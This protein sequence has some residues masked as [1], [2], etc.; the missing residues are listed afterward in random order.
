MAAFSRPRVRKQ[1]PHCVP[2]RPTPTRRLRLEAL[3]DRWVPAISYQITDVNLAVVLSGNTGAV[4]SIALTNSGTNTLEINGVDT[5]ILSADVLLVN[6]VGDSAGAANDAIDLS[7]VA[8]SAFAGLVLVTVDGGAGGNALKVNDQAHDFFF[9]ATDGGAGSVITSLS[10]FIDFTAIGSFTGG[11]GN[12][13]FVFAD[14]VGAT[15][16][17]DGGGGVNTLDYS[18][19]TT[20]VSVNLPTGAATNVF[21]GLAGGVTGVEN[22]T[23]GFGNDTLLGDASSNV[24]TGNDGNDILATGPGGTDALLGGSGNDTFRVAVAAGMAVTIQ[25]GN[26]NDTIDFSSSLLT[27]VTVDLD[28]FTPQTI[29]AGMSLQFTGPDVVENFIGTGVSDTVTVRP[30]GVPRSIDGNTPVLPTLPGD[31]VLLD[32]TSPPLPVAPTGQTF[33]Y[34]G[35]GD[36]FYT[37]NEYAQVTFTSIETF[38][39]TSP[40]PNLVINANAINRD[41]RVVRNGAN[42]EIRDITNPA[43]FPGVPYFVYAYTSFDTLTINGRTSDSNRV[44]LDFI[45]G[46]VANTPIQPLGFT[47]NGDAI[48]SGPLA[49]VDRLDIASGTATAAFGT[50]SVAYTGTESGTSSFTDTSLNALGEIAF[51]GVDEYDLSGGNLAPAYDFS[52][53]IQNLSFN[54][55]SLTGPLAATFQDSG[56]VADGVSRV[57]TSAPGPIQFVPTVFTNPTTQLSVS[58]GTGLGNADL[59]QLGDMDNNFAPTDLVFTG[60]DTTD[61]YRLTSTGFLNTPAPTLTLATTTFDMNG[62]SDTVAWVEDLADGT[63]VLNLGSAATLTTGDAT[64][65]T[66]N[67]VISG[68]GNFIKQGIGSWTLGGTLTNTYTGSATVNEGSLLLNKGN[69]SVAVGGALNIGDDLG[70]NDVDLVQLIGGNGQIISTSLVRVNTTGLLSLNNF[71]NTIGG[72]TMESGTTVAGTVTM[73]LGTLTLGTGANVTLSPD[74]APGAVVPADINGI[75]NL[76]T[77]SHTF[78]IADGTTVV[79]GTGAATDVDLLVNA[80]VVGA[81]D[82]IKTGTGLV[83]LTSTSNTY[84]GTTTINQGVFNL[85]GSLT[86]AGGGVILNGPS[87][88]FSGSDLGRLVGDGRGITVTG[89]ASSNATISGFVRIFNSTVGATGITVQSGAKVR[90]IDNV[91]LVAT[92]GISGHAV[93]ILV[94]GATDAT[95]VFLRGNRI[96]SN[97]AS[98]SVG[99]RIQGGAWV[100]AGQKNN[101]FDFTGLR[102]NLASSPL[103]AGSNGG[104]FFGQA[105][106]T[107]QNA[108]STLYGAIRNQNNNSPNSLAGPQGAPNDAY[109][110]SNFFNGAASAPATYGTIEGLVYHD[111]DSSPLGFV[112]YITP[113]SSA[114]ALVGSPL[115]YSVTPTAAANNN[116]DQR[117]MIRRIRLSFTDFVFVDIGTALNLQRTGGFAATGGNYIGGITVQRNSPVVFNPLA[118]DGRYFNYDFNFTGNGVEVSG[119]LVDG[120]YTLAINGAGIQSYVPFTPAP[121]YGSFPALQLTNPPASPLAFH[122]LFGDFNN[123]ATVNNTP[124]VPNG[125]TDQ[126]QFNSTY[127]SIRGQAKYLEYFDFDNDGDVDISDQTQF[128]RRMNRY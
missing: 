117:S 99:L 101:G 95:R 72:L 26:G 75:L 49:G 96:N 59:V 86:G 108:T 64:N 114:P 82:V 11:A 46:S 21:G 56:G 91:G 12:D 69:G 40:I 37:S 30:L 77:G 36:S 112:N 65:H 60:D 104:N 6:L 118:T 93:N 76:V 20:D 51:T 105:G 48:N 17:I 44:I 3:E 89:G 14:G 29:A 92:D 22:A 61:I 124:L 125:P 33:T 67:G 2:S 4:D 73:G 19:Y 116:W 62:F 41:F 71:N 85:P 66:Y 88:V 94:N 78:N 57:V 18:S 102:V 31:T 13:A 25:D 111:Y 35:P 10:Y 70:G 23:G 110:Q 9:N 107:Y 103:G 115:L 39:S 50:I 106:A 80:T 58:A 38:S 68:T 42:V 43:Y 32:N 90:I 74:G 109:A 16:T 97:A 126:T 7:G 8:P 47:F 127:R 128:N 24:L 28:S 122:R 98:T 119:S 81:G 123:T 87:A 120:N 34:V 53:T 79:D 84:S 55:G 52:T 27:G 121:P 63:S 5:G 15:G 1:S 83:R 100:D 113:S 54:F 45:D